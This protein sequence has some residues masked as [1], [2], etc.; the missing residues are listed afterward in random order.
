MNEQRGH[1]NNI[2]LRVLLLPLTLL[3]RIS[4]MGAFLMTGVLTLIGFGIYY[5]VNSDFL[6]FAAA[7]LD[8]MDFS[9]DYTQV[10]DGQNRRWDIS[11]ESDVDTTFN[12]V[13]RHVS[14]WREED[15]PFA[16][17][18][19]LVT[20]GE[21]ASQGRVHVSVMMH[22]FTYRYD[23]DPSPAG[24]IN[25]LHIVPASEEIYRQLLKVR[26][27]DQVSIR[28]REIL[29]IERFDPEG[30]FVG[31]WQDAGCNSILVHSVQ[32]HAKGTPIP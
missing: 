14:H 3:T 10:L 30:Q 21:F 2:L 18:D 23:E 5:S 16:T 25:L 8:E 1:R 15:I 13:V 32:I 24:S 22:T 12:G 19:I 26:D 28:G 6:G 31:A 7:P 9:P 20:S 11:F 17:H 27:W 29:R 4:P